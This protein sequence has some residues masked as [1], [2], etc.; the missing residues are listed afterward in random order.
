MDEHKPQRSA[1]YYYT[2]IIIVVMFLNALIFPSL[3]DKKWLR[4]TMES[5]SQCW[6]QE[7]LNLLR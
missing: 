1:L 6:I 7:R 3:M 4:L 2:V 5:F